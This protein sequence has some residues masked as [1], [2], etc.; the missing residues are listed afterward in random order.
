MEPLKSKEKLSKTAVTMLIAI[1]GLFGALLT[2]GLLVIFLAYRF[3]RPLAF[4]V[5]LFLGCALSAAKVVLLEKALNRAVELG[6]EK[7][8][9]YARLQMILRY[10]LTILVVLGA[11]FFREV[12]G[13]FGMIAGLLV[14]QAAS[15]IA[16]AVLKGKEV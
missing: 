1:A 5:G 7:A 11:V 8:K 14:L 6:A 9:N 2:A 10:G 12:V 16:S 13:V 15:Y 3:E 4:G